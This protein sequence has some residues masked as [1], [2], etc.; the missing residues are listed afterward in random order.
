MQGTESP[1]FALRFAKPVACRYKIYMSEWENLPTV[2]RSY[3]ICLR[4]P[5]IQGC[6]GSRQEPA[7]VVIGLSPWL[8]G[9]LGID[10]T[11]E[12]AIH[13][14]IHTYI[15]SPDAPWLVWLRLCSER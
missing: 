7:Q 6:Q 13:C 5:H 2:V 11:L 12:F 1:V 10:V 9:S 4:S 14:L 3:R 8:A 15:S